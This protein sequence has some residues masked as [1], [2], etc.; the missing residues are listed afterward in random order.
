MIGAPSPSTRRRRPLVGSLV[1]T[2]CGSRVSLDR[3]VLDFARAE[4]VRALGFEPDR[5]ELELRGCCA[6]CRADGLGAPAGW[7]RA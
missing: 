2:R 1:C 5:G 7:G 6:A 4:L 3:N